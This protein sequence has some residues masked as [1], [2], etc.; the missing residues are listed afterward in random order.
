MDLIVFH[1]DRGILFVEIKGGA[2][3]GWG[4]TGT[5]GTSTPA[6]SAPMTDQQVETLRILRSIKRLLVEGCAGSGKT[7]LAVR[8]A[9][10]HLQQGKRVLLTCFNKYLAAYPRL[11]PDVSSQATA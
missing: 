7:L 10:N 2:G 6:K 11:L 4:G 9:H 8:L 3:W 1:P 5:T